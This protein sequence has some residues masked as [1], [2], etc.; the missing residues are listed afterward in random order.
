MVSGLHKLRLSV[1]PPV[2]HTPFPQLSFWSAC[3]KRSLPVRCA[4]V[5][6]GCVCHSRQKQSLHPLM[7]I[8]SLRLAPA[9]SL[10]QQQDQRVRTW[11]LFCTSNS[12]RSQAREISNPDRRKHTGDIILVF[13]EHLGDRPVSALAVSWGNQSHALFLSISCRSAVLWGR[14]TMIQSTVSDI[15]W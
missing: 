3:W 10:I 7:L 2:Q 5:L 4:L 9:D 14:P 12:I 13:Q 6:S 15:K 1:K 8:R 11:R